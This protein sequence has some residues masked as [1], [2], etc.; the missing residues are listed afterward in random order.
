MSFGQSLV[1]PPIFT[2]NHYSCRW[3]CASITA[4]RLNR[5]GCWLSPRSSRLSPHQLT[6]FSSGC[7][8]KELNNSRLKL[9]PSVI[10]TAILTPV[11][12]TYIK[13]RNSKQK[14]SPSKKLNRILGSHLEKFSKVAFSCFKCNNYVT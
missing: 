8:S 7:R 11:P 10:I 1:A 5:S 13:L 12:N 2:S 3:Y 6:L 4:D 14:R 9:Q